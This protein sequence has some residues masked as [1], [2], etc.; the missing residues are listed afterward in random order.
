[1]RAF[2]NLLSKVIQNCFGFKDKTRSTLTLANQL[3]NLDQWR[4][5]CPRFTLNEA[6]VKDLRCLLIGSL[7]WSS[8]LSLD[9]L[10]LVAPLSV[11]VLRSL[12]KKQFLQFLKNNS[13]SLK[14][15]IAYP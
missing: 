9:D 6:G 12:N 10:I 7:S 15:F 2:F 8:L 13:T 11:L 3:Q 1:M 5:W 14:R 4:N